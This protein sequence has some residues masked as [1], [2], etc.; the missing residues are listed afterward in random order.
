MIEIIIFKKSKEIFD[1]QPIKSKQNKHCWTHSLH[2]QEKE[3]N[4]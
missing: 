2:T 3:T 1:Y 4:T